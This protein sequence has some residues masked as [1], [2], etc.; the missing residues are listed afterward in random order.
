LEKIDP[1]TTPRFVIGLDLGQVA[2]Y[3]ALAG[4]EKQEDGRLV[5]RQLDR[6]RGRPYPKIVAD[7][8]RAVERLAASNPPPR[9]EIMAGLS[10]PLPVAVLA[11]DATG[12]GAA[13][14]DLLRE[15]GMPC[16]L[17]PVTI[18][19]GHGVTG[20]GKGGLHVPKK[21][22]VGAALVLLQS[23]RLVLSRE[24][25]L[26]D[27][28]VREMDTFQVRI[29]AAGNETFGTWREGQHD[30]LVLAV[31]LACWAAEN[32]PKPST[33]PLV[34]WPPVPKGPG[35][36]DQTSGPRS[37]LQELADDL[38]D[39]RRFIDGED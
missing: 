23:G 14:V 3:T 28:L 35:E 17:L 19:A 32:G 20:D 2:D 34:Y 8:S 13:V 6:A 9:L 29:T 7:V 12:V 21:D 33:G 10:L 31:S 30:D 27:T 4:L 38:P 18:T 15:A 24:L 22:L 5:L 25:P 36:F 16:R 26:I 39:L 37:G 11:V 1:M